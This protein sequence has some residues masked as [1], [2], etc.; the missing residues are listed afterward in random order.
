[1]LFEQDGRS[2][3][4]VGRRR[5]SPGDEEENMTADLVD[6]EFL[7]EGRI[8]RGWL[9][10]PPGPGPHPAVAMAPGFAAVRH[11][12]LG[13]PFHEVFVRSGLAV[14]LF[15]N[16]HCG[17][18]DGEPR[19]ELDPIVQQRGYRDGLTFLALHERI[20][21]ERMG[22]WGTS[23]SGGH[24]LAV[25]AADRRVKC[26]VSQAMTISGR[27]NLRRRLTPAAYSELNTAWYEDRLERARG[28]PARTV[29]AFAEDSESVAFANQRP[30]EHRRNWH[31]EV[32]LRS[33]EYY[34]EYSP[35][36]VIERISP[37]PLLMIIALDDKMTPAE[38]ALAA[39]NRAVEPKK[40]LTVPGGHY[41]VYE[42]DG[43]TRAASAAA[44]W[45]RQHLT[46]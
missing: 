44:D 35:V 1:M 19:Q 2:Q 3:Y 41:A 18:S 37:T 39:Y 20:D 14:L 28:A 34:A 16:A 31:N 13:H 27:S 10:L 7:S 23:Y 12:F 30:A 33:W 17:D 25:A 46:I 4:Q 38:D 42:G 22:I 24:V 26:V 5:D 21:A 45:F 43:Y 36:D 40:L 11:G 32:T 9:A 8:L 15:D 29:V 6:V